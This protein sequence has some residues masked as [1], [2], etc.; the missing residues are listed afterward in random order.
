MQYP[1]VEQFGRIARM[2]AHPQGI[3][4]KPKTSGMAVASLVCGILGLICI[5]ILPAFLGL[6]FSI[7]AIRKINGSGGAVGGKGLAV[8]GLITSV[9]GGIIYVALLALLLLPALTEA[10]N[11]ANRMKCA[12]NIKTI[13]MSYQSFAN[14][15]DGQ[16]PH[17]YGGFA[18][19]AD[20]NIQA[21]ALG[22]SST[23]DPY[24]TT[25]WMSAH[26]IRQS[27]YTPKSLVSPVDPEAIA[28]QRRMGMHEFEDGSP[29]QVASESQSYAIAMQGDLYT[30]DTL[31]IMTRN[32][33]T[34]SDAKRRA[35]Y[36][37]KGGRNSGDIW[38][39]PNGDRPWS[40]HVGAAHIQD[41]GMFGYAAEFHGEDGDEDPQHTMAG[42]P[43]EEAN[44]G[45]SDGA[46]RM[47]REMEFNDQ[48]SRAQDSF[49]EGNAIAP[50]LNLTV[51]RPQQ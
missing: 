43:A 38:S 6:I 28:A 7:I 3:P 36:Q 17:L 15:I 31:L 5:P 48:L 27:L 1:L 50:G 47:G 37:A 26:A 35:W 45:T 42:M 11:K 23:D 29:V 8:G 9:I 4:A 13:N 10:K 21:Q 34:A 39:Y 49:R 33:K 20:G 46:V 2:E 19:G 24:D 30:A 51:L 32:I 22:Y 12:N 14:E 44:W 41:G 16:T 25:R 18:A 40:K